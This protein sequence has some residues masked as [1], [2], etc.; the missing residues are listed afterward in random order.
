METVL[1]GRICGSDFD[2]EG[3]PTMIEFEIGDG[4]KLSIVTSD[5]SPIVPDIDVWTDHDHALP[6]VK[7]RVWAPATTGVRTVRDIRRDTRRRPD[8]PPPGG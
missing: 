8:E 2:D 7:I 4:R 6:L 1:D 5:G 3:R